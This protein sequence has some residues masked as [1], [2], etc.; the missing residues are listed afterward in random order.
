[1]RL[2]PAP[3]FTKNPEHVVDMI[4]AK[5]SFQLT[6]GGEELA[7]SRNVIEVHES[8]HPVRLYFPVGDVQMDAL[9]ANDHSSYCP[10]K[11]EARYWS[12]HTKSGDLDNAV[13]AYD[14]PYSECAELVGHVC[15][16][17]DKPGFELSEVT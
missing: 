16:Y 2:E 9:I 7:R 4:P 17:T 3:G 13:W 10:Y 12:I 5:K 1:M 8:K 14:E 11:G 6:W 15:F